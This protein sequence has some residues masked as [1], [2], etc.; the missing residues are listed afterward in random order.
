[1][2]IFEVLDLCWVSVIGLVLGGVVAFW[3]LGMSQ[4]NGTTQRYNEC[5][6]RMYSQPT[7]RSLDDVR[8]YCEYQ[9]KYRKEQL[10]TSTLELPE[11]DH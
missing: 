8:A 6:V 10:D 5:V 1:M 4:H 3:I 9:E 11:S 7:P 2:K